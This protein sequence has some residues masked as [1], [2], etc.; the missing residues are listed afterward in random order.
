MKK[1][2]KIGVWG[3]FGS[4]TEKIADGQAVKTNILYQELKERFGANRIVISN[5]NNWK[6]N[7]IKFFYKSILLVIR[8]KKVI[9]LPADNGFKVFVPLL[10]FIN[11]FLKRRL[12]YV[13]IGGFLPKLL[14]Q[15]PK[16]IKYL[17]KYGGLFVETPNLKNSLKE[18]GLN[19]VYFLP[20]MKKLTRISEHALKV[21][22]N[23]NVTVCTFSRITY[24]KGIEHAIKGVK[25]ANNELGSHVIKL[26]IF[27]MID[28]KYDQK[29]QELLYT[30]S[31]FVTYK[32]IIDYDKTVES[33]KDYFI[34]LFPTFFPGEGFAGTLIDAFH[35]AL[36]IIATD[37]LYNS[38]I[39]KH[40]KNGILVPIKDP[41]KIAEALI[42]MY[43]DRDFTY[44]IALNNLR[45]S[46]K[47]TPKVVLGE[48]FEMLDSSS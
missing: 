43:K 40:N 20:N 29:F 17:R 33:L 44:N 13:V 16:Y 8:S 19:K 28:S 15:N 22:T 36:P 5:T 38:E 12:Y 2:D 34:M 3:Q 47:Y 46:E 14:R 25:I 39:I 37:W 21:N 41:E 7:P 26:D 23:R 24:T 48:I 1:K 6:R 31:D 11:I 35:S 18:L 30:H 27:G 9:I 32:G 45:E 10:N 4:K 42:K